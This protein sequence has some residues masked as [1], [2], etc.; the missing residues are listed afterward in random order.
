MKGLT[1]A[2]ITSLYCLH[3]L[4][5]L[6]GNRANDQGLPAS[7]SQNK[8]GILSEKDLCYPKNRK[9]TNFAWRKIWDLQKNVLVW[10]SNK[11]NVGE[12]MWRSNNFLRLTKDF[13]CR[14]LVICGN[15]DFNWCGRSCL[16]SFENHWLLISGKM[17]FPLWPDFPLL[18]CCSYVLWPQKCLGLLWVSVPTSV[19]WRG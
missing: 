8:Y 9:F 11:E 6:Q 13:D 14:S 16:L 5:F 4:Q 17:L 3:S 7:D 1:I 18:G 15:M 12:G 19:R 2:V 10:C